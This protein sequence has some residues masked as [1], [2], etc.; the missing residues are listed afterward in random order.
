M[1]TGCRACGHGITAHSTTGPCAVPYCA[2]RDY[3]D[4]VGCRPEAHDNVRKDV[5]HFHERTRI[6][7]IQEGP[8]R[9][10][11]GVCPTCGTTL[12]VEIPGCFTLRAD[13][14]PKYA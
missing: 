7:G 10:L 14:K 2:C 6:V 8:V 13:L 11:L 3:A 4:P 12:A 5:T 9:L 1:T